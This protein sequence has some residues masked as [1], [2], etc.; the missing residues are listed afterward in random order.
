MAIQ[1]ITFSKQLVSSNDDAH[2][3]KLFLNGRSGKTKGCTMTFGGDDIYISNGYFFIANRLVK[4]TSLE[5]VSTPIVSTGTT[6]NRL[7]FEIDLTKTNTETTFEQGYFK[8][9]S[10]SSDYPEI[11]QEDI[12]NGGNIYQMPFARFT[13]T[14]GGIGTFKSELESI[15]IAQEGANIYVTTSGNDASGDGSESKPFRTIQHAIDSVAKNIENNEI[16]INIASGTY[17]EDVEIG[18]FSGA[19]LRFQ[20][21]SI[22]INSLSIYDSCVVINGTTL[23][24]A[25]NG[26]TYGLYCHRDANVICQSDLTINGSEHGIYT[27]YGSRLNARKTTTINS[28][29]FAVSVTF[30]AMVYLSSL[31]GSKNNNGV[32]V[33]GGHVSFGSINA[34]M[35]STLYVTGNGGR[36]YSGSQTS[37]PAY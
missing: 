27:G 5:T 15:G 2:I 6:Y 9:L 25:A 23:T 17:S 4:I 30:A 29:T 11:T 12:E 8:I 31:T 33:S 7:V 1:G 14:V 10:S 21:G 26:K 22:T 37:V 16:T 3:Y 34:S 35:A 13:K 36:I 32:Q 28:C 18:G 19:P 24:I 20:I